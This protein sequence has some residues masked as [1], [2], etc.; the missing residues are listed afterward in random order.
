MMS[1]E[2]LVGTIYLLRIAWKEGCGILDLQ[3]SLRA[4]DFEVLGLLQIKALTLKVSLCLATSC[5]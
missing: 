5:L 2:V 3:I 4:K 1:L